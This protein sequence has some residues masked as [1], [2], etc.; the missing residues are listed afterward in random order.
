M[1]R[2]PLCHM[3]NAPLTPTPFFPNSIS[4]QKTLLFVL[5]C[6]RGL[7]TFGTLSLLPRPLRPPSRNRTVRANDEQMSNELRWKTGAYPSNP[8]V[9][10]GATGLVFRRGVLS[11]GC[12]PAGPEHKRAPS[13]RA[14]LRGE[15]AGGVGRSAFRKSLLTSTGFTD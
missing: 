11:G 15:R 12:A 5:H 1:V 10:L 6:Y 9:E 2:N 13:S 14:F 3:R 7:A 8:G 4:Q